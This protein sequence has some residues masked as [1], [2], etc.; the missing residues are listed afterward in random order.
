V[1]LKRASP[2]SLA[3]HFIVVD[4]IIRITYNGDNKGT[5]NMLT[6]VKTAA[7]F[8]KLPSTI[9]HIIRGGK[10]KVTKAERSFALQNSV[11]TAINEQWISLEL[12][13]EILISNGAYGKRGKE[14]L[15]DFNV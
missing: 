5:D 12:A 7:D 11:V 13:K 10:G 9:K 6:E 2:K 15:K 3:V 14:V 1:L 8:E 4:M